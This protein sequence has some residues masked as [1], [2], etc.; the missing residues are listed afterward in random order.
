MEMTDLALSIE[1]G[2]CWRLD[3]TQHCGT[4]NELV[5]EA[6]QTEPDGKWADQCSVS[7]ALCNFGWDALI[8]YACSGYLN[9]NLGNDL[10]NE[11]FT[12]DSYFGD[13]V[14][15]VDIPLSDDPS[16]NA[17]RCSNYL[18]NKQAD[19]SLSFK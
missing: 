18:Y 12:N 11:N 6:S 10:S 13:N 17:E 16:E 1:T 19:G 14:G 3:G 15:I 5:H 9:G 2:S 7:K 8:N 4:I